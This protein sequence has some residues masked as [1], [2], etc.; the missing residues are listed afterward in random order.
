M[1]K[2]CQACHGQRAFGGG[3]TRRVSHF[4]R[5]VGYLARLGGLPQMRCMALGVSAARL[6]TRTKEC[7]LPASLMAC[8]PEG[9]A[10]AMTVSLD[11]G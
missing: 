6:E 9:V 5:T 3:E 2:C 8:K 11:A 1:L 4:L 10:N 7:T